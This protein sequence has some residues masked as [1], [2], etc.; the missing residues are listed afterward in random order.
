MQSLR[1][2]FKYLNV[3]MLWLWRLGLGPLLSVW[4]LLACFL[5]FTRR[6]ANRSHQPLTQSANPK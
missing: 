6:R 5:L 1:T 2:F 4:P 3:G